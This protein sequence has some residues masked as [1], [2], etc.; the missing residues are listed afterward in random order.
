MGDLA[1]NLGEVIAKGSNNA[2]TMAPETSCFDVWSHTADGLSERMAQDALDPVGATQRDIAALGEAGGNFIDQ[3]S[4]GTVASTSVDGWIDSAIAQ[5]DA[6]RDQGAALLSGEMTMPDGTTKELSALERVGLGFSML[7]GLEQMISTM[8]SVIPF[9]AF[10]ALRV[11]DM[12]IGFPH[13]HMHPP[14]FN[15]PVVPSPIPFP[16]TGP[17]IPIPFLSGANT[18][19]INGMPAARCGDMGLGIWCGGYFPMYEVFLGSSSVWIEGARAGRVLCDITKHCIFSTPRPS[20]F[21]TYTFLGTTVSA[22]PNVMIGGV[23]MPSLAGMAMGA[24]FGA[25][26]RRMGQLIRRAQGT[27]LGQ[28]LAQRVQERAA[29]MMGQRLSDKA[30]D[31]IHRALCFLLGHPVDAATGKVLAFGHDINWAGPARLRFE[32]VWASSS[33]YDGPLGRGWTHSYDM[34]LGLDG[35]A[36]VVWLSDGRAVPMAAPTEES[37]AESPADG[38]TL[39]LT[40]EG[41]VMTDA[42]GRAHLFGPPG[43]GGLRPLLRITEADGAETRLSY[44]AAGHLARIAV[45]GGLALEVETDAR[46]RITALRGPDPESG[47]PLILRSFAYDAAGDLVEVRDAYGQPT[48]YAYRNHMLVRETD[49]NGYAYRFEY[50][51]YDI[52]GRC[53]RTWGDGPA[54]DLRFEYEPFAG[55]TTVS[56]GQGKRVYRHDA[57]GLV[58][59]L[60]DARGG[61]TRYA[62]D[63]ANR[64]VAERAPDGSETR[65]APDGAL[66]I[67]IKGALVDTLPPPPV[68]EPS[69]DAKDPPGLARDL[70]GRIT[71]QRAGGLTRRFAWDLENRIVEATHPAGGSE[72]YG[73]DA[74]GRLTSITDRAGRVTRYAHFAENTPAAQKRPDGSVI[75]AEHN[76][77]LG[78]V[79]AEDANGNRLVFLRDGEDALTEIRGASGQLLRRIER[80][81]AGQPTRVI[82]PLTRTEHRRDARP[83]CLIRKRTHRG[84]DAV[85]RSETRLFTETRTRDYA[86]DAVRVSTRLDEAGR[87]AGF[88]FAGHD[89]AWAY[90][91]AGRETAL[92]TP[93]GDIAY[94]HEPEGLVLTDPLGGRHLFGRDGV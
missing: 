85:L 88:S 33:A 48:T 46:G 73:Y 80:D 25:M 62:Y 76:A 57:Q 11:T 23:P 19:T 18:V 94:A 22:S 92:T 6:L 77:A 69:K 52:T 26:F 74:G 89:F 4:D 83:G 24:A 91:T 39:A 29:R 5:Q 54:L 45:T 7:T 65:F 51:R 81:A 67:H 60:V 56:N 42:A 13:G 30:R 20:D 63:A 10:P 75:R 21:P 41:P 64:L 58:T 49:R 12:D 86:D 79:A 44:S 40:P 66:Q 90:D 61:V 68:P 50:D 27:K 84:E 15:P 14:N 59:E 32:R 31:R 36:A 16:S 71:E 3:F 55:R 72:R 37:P 87:M 9:P 47:E 43:P 82:G 78:L 38:V 2:A 53:L 17:I 28:R 1:G 70:W 8:L 93:W 35:R 34:A